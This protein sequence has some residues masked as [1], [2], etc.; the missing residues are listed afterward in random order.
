MTYASKQRERKAA[1]RS[2]QR[3]RRQ[4]QTLVGRMG[5]QVQSCL[6]ARTLLD[7]Q[8]VQRIATTWNQAM[9]KVADVTKNLQAFAQIVSV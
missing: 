9:S 7:Y 3:E 5:R 2:L 6:Q 1:A 8:D 4:L